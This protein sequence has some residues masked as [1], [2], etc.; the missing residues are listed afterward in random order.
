MGGIYSELREGINWWL[1]PTRH[2]SELRPFMDS[3]AAYEQRMKR[4]QKLIPEKRREPELLPKN[5]ND[6]VV[7][8]K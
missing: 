5:E 6:P 8:L 3:R 4:T 1:T 2:N 7:I